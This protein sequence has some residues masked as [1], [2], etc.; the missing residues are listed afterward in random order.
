MLNNQ[1]V[2]EQAMQ[3]NISSK[4]PCVYT[5]A[6]CT[7]SVKHFHKFKGKP[8]EVE[9]RTRWTHKIHLSFDWYFQLVF[10]DPAT[11]FQDF[12]NL[13]SSI[14]N[15]ILSKYNTLKYKYPQH[16]NFS[17]LTYQDEQLFWFKSNN[18]TK[19]RKNPNWTADV[20]KYF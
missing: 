1:R 14:H 6:C 9:P 4:I 2:A 19:L 20:K 12:L 3:S 5:A 11:F 17:V 10:N 8:V 15:I 18:I 13:S 16:E 7:S